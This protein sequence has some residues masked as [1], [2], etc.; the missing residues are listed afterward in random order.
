M[1][2]WDGCGL[3]ALPGACCNYCQQQGGTWGSVEASVVG[4]QDPVL[5]MAP[6]ASIRT[7]SHLQREP[8]IVGHPDWRSAASGE[9]WLLHPLTYARGLALPKY[10]V[11]G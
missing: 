11:T 3:A 1:K 4:M 6:A 7:C 9:L 10:T 2:L 5:D 8:A